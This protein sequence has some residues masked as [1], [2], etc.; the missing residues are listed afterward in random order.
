MSISQEQISSIIQLTQEGYSSRKIAELL[1][2]GSKTTVNNY[3]KELGIAIGDSSTIKEQGGKILFFDLETAPSVCLSFQRWNTNISPQSILQ[4]GGW[5]LSAAWKFSGD[6]KVS[7]IALNPKEAKQANDERIVATLYDLFEE[8]DIVCGHNLMK[9]DLGVFKSRLVA[10]HFP[11]AK[12]V[13]TIDTLRI[14]KNLRFNSN[15]LDSL[16]NYLGV[17]R[18]LDHTGIALWRD[19]MDGKQDALDMM[20]AYNKQDVQLLEDVYHELKAFDPKHPNMGQYFKDDLH[21]C[22]VCGSADVTE[23]GNAVYS[24]ASSF[25]EVVCNSCGHRSRKRTA[26]DK[27]NRKKNLLVTPPVSG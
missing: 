6:T 21:R 20:L 3:R 7:G 4:E 1:G 14:A 22:T 2:I 8:A 12:T 15:K 24:S 25:A 27:G 11:P 19:C 17:G 16:G 10:N 26:I 5:L 23:T 13:K 9:F 18:K